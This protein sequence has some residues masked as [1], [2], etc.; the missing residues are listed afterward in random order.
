[1]SKQLEELFWLA[2]T[3]VY[4]MLGVPGIAATQ[5]PAPGTLIP[6]RLGYFLRT[7]KH[8]ATPTDWKAFLDFADAQWSP[9]RR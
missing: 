3:P 4:Q 6:S 8:A 2:A 1:L 5:M 9:P 7:G